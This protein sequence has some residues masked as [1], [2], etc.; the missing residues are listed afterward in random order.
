MLYSGLQI[1]W[2]SSYM[3]FKIDNDKA[4]WFAINAIKNLCYD[5][6]MIV[7]IEPFKAKRSTPQN[8]LLWASLISDFVEQGFVDGRQFSAECWHEYLKREFLPDPGE[9]TIEGYQKW[10]E[11][12]DG[13]LLL[14]G[15]TTKLTTK[16]F[17]NYIEKCYSFGCEIG[18]RFG[19]NLPNRN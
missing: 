18:I 16:G 9:D 15:S 14:T 11:L 5:K 3:K 1:N 13:K 19:C 6:I 8:A 12:P 7:S 17:S 4:K 10:T 2:H